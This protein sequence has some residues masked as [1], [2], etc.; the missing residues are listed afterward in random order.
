[1]HYIPDFTNPHM[2]ADTGYTL[3]MYNNN[4]VLTSE[5]HGSATLTVRCKSISTPM[6]VFAMLHVM[7]RNKVVHITTSR[8]FHQNVP[9]QGITKKQ[10]YVK[11]AFLS[12]ISCHDVTS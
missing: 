9:Q 4:C 6:S 5:Y 3:L 10:Y 2:C 1:M 7:G 12:F 11:L 8:K